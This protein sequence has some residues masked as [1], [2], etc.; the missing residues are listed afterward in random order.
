MAVLDLENPGKNKLA[1]VQ[2][3]KE[4]IDDPVQI[5]YVRL[6][7]I[8]SVQERDSATTKRQ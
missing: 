6:H 2:N 3:G 5:R 4:A 7:K 1:A 8:R